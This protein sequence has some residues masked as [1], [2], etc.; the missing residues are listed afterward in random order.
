VIVTGP[1]R[2][3][4]GSDTPIY[5]DD[6]GRT[7]QPQGASPVG[8][9]GADDLPQS[10]TNWGGT[11][12]SSQ[13]SVMI[14]AATE[15]YIAA[16][17]DPASAAAQAQSDILDTLALSS[18]APGQ[19]GVVNALT[20][21]LPSGFVSTSSNPDTSPSLDT[22]GILDALGLGSDVDLTDP[23]T[24][25]LGTWLLVLGGGILVVVFLVRR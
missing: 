25:G 17:M 9:P 12:S 7:I 15:A 4:V 10:Y 2:I 6:F 14:S 13:A 5:V 19:A 21:V 24:W 3:G 20:P 1:T 11:L 8:I 23:S 16:G 22:S 18:S